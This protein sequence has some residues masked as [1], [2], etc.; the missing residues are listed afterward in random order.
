MTQIINTMLANGIAS[1]N[2][3][4]YHYHIDMIGTG[5]WA[6]FRTPL[7]KWGFNLTEAEMI[8]TVTAA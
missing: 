2:L 5:E 6:L 8:A 4:G 7:H 3:N 1:L